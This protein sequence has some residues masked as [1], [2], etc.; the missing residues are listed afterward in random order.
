MKG[1]SPPNQSEMHMAQVDARI[2]KK[3]ESLPE[4]AQDV[5]RLIRLANLSATY[6][7][8][9]WNALNDHNLEWTIVQSTTESID[10]ALH[11]ALRYE[12][13]NMSNRK[14]SLKA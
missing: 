2:R 7:R 3:D 12:A 10:E 1:F 5:K 13:N 4:L 14:P 9:F 8:A 6:H 11:L